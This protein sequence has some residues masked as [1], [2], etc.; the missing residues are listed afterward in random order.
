MLSPEPPP[1]RRRPAPRRGMRLWLDVA[2]AEWRLA[3]KNLTAANLR[4]F[5]KNLMWVIPLTVL[6]WVYAAHN[7]TKTVPSVSARIQIKQNDPNDVI[8]VTNP[9]DQNI[10]LTLTGPNGGLNDVITALH[11]PTP[12]IIDP[13]TL[14]PGPNNVKM[15]DQI[16]NNSLFVSKGVTVEEV[17]PPQLSMSVDTL[18]SETFTVVAPENLNLESAPTFSPSSVIVRAPSL[19]MDQIDAASNGHPTIVADLANLDILNTPGDHTVN[20][21]SLIKPWPDNP[22]VAVLP[23]SVSA[24]LNVKSADVQWVVPKMAIFVTMPYRDSNSYTVHLDTDTQF[25]ANVNVK[26]P[27]AG[28]K[29]LQDP[30]WGLWGQI[31]IDNAHS[32]VH[33]EAE[34]IYNL[35]P[36]VVCTDDEAHRTVGYTVVDRGS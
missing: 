14:T 7:E 22:S 36:G 2:A 26:G 9:P 24:K 15:L 33:G 31:I 25:M 27:P 19:L 13:G 23:T 32:G 10:V 34:V 17:A 18:K 20:G 30:N 11:S 1:P 29:Q 35:P 3:R 5:G 12:I 21:V 28:I 8:T 16:Q 4:I 6:I